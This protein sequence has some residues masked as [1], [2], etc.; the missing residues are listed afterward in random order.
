[1]VIFAMVDEWNAQA[2]C[3]HLVDVLGQERV[4]TAKQGPRLSPYIKRVERLLAEG[5]ICHGNHAV[6]NWQVRNTVAVTDRY[7]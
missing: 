3:S 2:I 1:M 7:R 4:G 5:L 6:L